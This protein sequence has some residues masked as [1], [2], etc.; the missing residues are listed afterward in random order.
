MRIDARG[1]LYTICDG[2]TAINTCCEKRSKPV[3]PLEAVDLNQLDAMVETMYEMLRYS[4]DKCTTDVE[5]SSTYH[6]W[7]IKTPPAPPS[8]PAECYTVARIILNGHVHD[9]NC[10]SKIEALTL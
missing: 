4:D 5:P 7:T 3:G 10:P 8:S 2:V 1:I 9:Q 6:A